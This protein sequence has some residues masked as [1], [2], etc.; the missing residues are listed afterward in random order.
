MIIELSNAMFPAASPFVLVEQLW[1]VDSLFLGNVFC[2][3]FCFPSSDILGWIFSGVGAQESFELAVDE[4]VAG[5]SSDAGCAANSLF[6]LGASNCLDFS[7]NN[8]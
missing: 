4:K 7:N 8:P 3:D 2:L 1:A 5:T 6:D